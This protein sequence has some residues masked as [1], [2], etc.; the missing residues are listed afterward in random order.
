MDLAESLQIPE[1][2]IHAHSNMGSSL[3][4]LG[5]FQ[6]SLEQ[7]QAARVIG[8]L[9]PIEERIEQSSDPDIIVRASEAIV[10]WYLGYPDQA[11]QR[12]TEAEALAEEHAN[13]YGLVFSLIFASGFYV[14]MR[15]PLK[16]RLTI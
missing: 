2:M 1:L 8:D 15:D 6:Q 5:R 7:F 13:L 16:V 4:R 11:E 10:L 9:L 12:I 14:R 3:T